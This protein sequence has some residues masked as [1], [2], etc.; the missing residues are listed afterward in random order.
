MKR[1]A[2]SFA[3][4]VFL[5]VT[6]VAALFATLWWHDVDIFPETFTKI[7]VDAPP[8][9][10]VSS[11]PP[12]VGSPPERLATAVSEVTE[13]IRAGAYEMLVCPSR[14][15]LGSRPNKHTQQRI[16]TLCE[17]WI[18]RGIVMVLNRVLRPSMLGVEWSAGS[19]SLWLLRKLAL[20]HSV[21]HCGGWLDA[22]SKVIEH[23]TPWLREKWH[24]H[25]IA[26]VC[27]QARCGD[28]AC[29]QE[30]GSEWDYTDYITYGTRN[31][32]P[33]HSK[34]FDF[35]SVDGRARDRVLQE[36]VST[37]ILKPYGILM[38]DNSERNYN[39]A[40]TVPKHWPT[41]TFQNSIGK[42][43]IWMKCHAHDENCRQAQADIDAAMR[44]VTS[45]R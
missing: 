25:P 15:Y 31:I 33:E 45:G 3:L 6:G 40:Q 26:K 41:V 2:A 5:F 30:E 38:L 19:S 12:Y 32:L 22:I 4:V 18:Q 20:L 1:R 8:A 10:R 28:D 11:S 36:A 23:E 34:G 21:E 39:Q 16:G 27:T 13:L 17:P 44:V 42:T 29:G 43:T 24:P 37:N 7:H 9:R 14:Q 35:V